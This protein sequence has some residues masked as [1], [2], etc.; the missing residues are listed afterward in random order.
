M[1]HEVG[2]DTAYAD[3]FA[4]ARPICDKVAILKWC[5]VSKHKQKVALTSL[6]LE[7]GA[8]DLQRAL[9]DCAHDGECAFDCLPALS[10]A[11][12]R[13]PLVGTQRVAR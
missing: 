4:V 12:C 8:P 2:S 7:L 9:A 10:S 11:Q 1:H 6:N 5:T 3:L 13:L